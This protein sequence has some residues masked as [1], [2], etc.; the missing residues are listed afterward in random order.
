MQR[1]IDAL[2]KVYLDEVRR[3]A[4][5]IVKIL[6]LIEQRRYS[7]QQFM[8]RLV[9]AITRREQSVDQHPEMA[10]PD[11]NQHV[12]KLTTELH[13]ALSSIRRSQSNG[14]ALPH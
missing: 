3:E 1:E 12:D 4:Q 5:T 6:A 14:E 13:H 2:I 11:V 9:G 7:Q 10:P 8:D